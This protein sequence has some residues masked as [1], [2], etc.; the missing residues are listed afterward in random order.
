[1]KTEKYQSCL[2]IFRV[3]SPVCKTEYIKIGKTNHGP[4]ARYTVHLTGSPFKLGIYMTFR[5]TEKNEASHW[6]RHL[7]LQMKKYITRGEWFLFN[8]ES[9][10]LLSSLVLDIEQNHYDAREDVLPRAIIIPNFEYPKGGNNI[11]LA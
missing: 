3:I 1:M 8:E 11:Y 5:F 2:Y 6:E 10:L 4:L 7:H 9:K